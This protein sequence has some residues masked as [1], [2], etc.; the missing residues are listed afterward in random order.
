MASSQLWTTSSY[1]HLNAMAG[2][3]RR[4]RVE[5]I[6]RAEGPIASQCR[7]GDDSGKIDRMIPAGWFLI[8]MLVA[9]P[10][11]KS[12]P[13]ASGGSIMPRSWRRR[14]WSL[15]GDFPV[16]SG[17]TTIPAIR[18]SYSPCGGMAG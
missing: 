2:T 15:V 12:V 16:F 11:S 7:R 6:G 14:D 13:S 5:H 9:D 3:V 10:C 8:T 1:F 17:R 18:P 4:S